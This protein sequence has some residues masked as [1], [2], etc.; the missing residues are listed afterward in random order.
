MSYACATCA[1][2]F[3]HGTVEADGVVDH[4]LGMRTAR[5]GGDG[6]LAISVRL[7]GDERAIR[8]TERHL[9]RLQELIAAS[10]P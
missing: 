4:I 8:F 2:K 6:Q 5:E 1:A 9:L 7:C 3:E 10:T